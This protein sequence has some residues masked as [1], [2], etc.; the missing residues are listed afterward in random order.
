MA[1]RILNRRQKYLTCCVYVAYVYNSLFNILDIVFLLLLLDII[2]VDI[3]L[4][5]CKSVMLDPVISCIVAGGYMTSVKRLRMNFTFN[6]L[7]L[8]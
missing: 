6:I 2:V 8:L 3:T 7:N 5:S 1:I 4:Y